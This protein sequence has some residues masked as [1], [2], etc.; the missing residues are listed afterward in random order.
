MPRGDSAAKGWHYCC[1]ASLEDAAGECSLS[2]L[3]RGGPAYPSGP[4]AEHDSILAFFYRVD[5]G[6]PG[7]HQRV[8]DRQ[9]RRSDEQANET[10]DDQA[11]NDAH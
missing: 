9:D 5:L 11:A 2:L 3:A 6:D 1:G 10:E 8:A 7:L 4:I